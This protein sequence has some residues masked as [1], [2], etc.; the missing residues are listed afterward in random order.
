MYLFVV[1]V[2]VG[3]ALYFMTPGERERLRRAVLA[4]LRGAYAA[5]ARSRR[6]HDAF[7]KA[8][9]ARTPWVLATP[10]LAALNIAIFACMLFSPGALSDPETLIQ[11]G[12]SFGPRTTNGEWWRL[13]TT[14]SVHSG[15]LHLLVNLAALVQVG[16]ILERLVGVVTFATVYVVAGVLA[17]LVCLSADAVAVS[18]GASGAIFGTYGL[19]LASL[20]RGALQRSPLT[21]PLATAKTFGPPA[22]AF[23]LY[24]V[25]FGSL[26]GAAHAASL[27]VGF[28]CGIV[29]TRG[30]SECEPAVRRAAVALAATAVIVVALAVPL[31]GL[32]DVRPEIQ[33]IIAAEDRT[34]Q[35]YETEIER[36]RNGRI[37]AAALA[38]FIDRTIIPE[39]QAAGARL[40]QLGRVPAEHQPLVTNAEQ[41]VRLRKESWGLRSEALRTASVAMLRKADR[42]EWAALEALMKIRP[43]D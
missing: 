10:A 9:R 15:I 29:L 43:A 24:N 26:D 40:K 8:L 34:A 19:L 37:S 5:G 20:L 31:S 13:V 12:G 1:L 36:F 6:K 22:A 18:V 23:I 16:L 14:M 17:S 11:W 3:A 27:A 7:D 39:M 32:A 28:G 38:R 33:Q 41:Y 30:A 25:A 42:A 2:L 35:A 4:A 21:I